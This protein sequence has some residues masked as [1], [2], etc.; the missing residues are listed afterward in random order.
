MND[1]KIA[2]IRAHHAAEVAAEAAAW[3]AARRRGRRQT[4]EEAKQS[5]EL[6]RICREIEAG[7]DPYPEEDGR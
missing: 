7:R 4:A 5:S 6:L 3:A 2:E 1:D